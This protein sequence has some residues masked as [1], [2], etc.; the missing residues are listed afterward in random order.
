[1]APQL[2][3]RK[4]KD[5]DRAQLP[6]GKLKDAEKL[7]LSSRKAKDGDGTQVS[8]R[9][10]PST[11]KGKHRISKKRTVSPPLPDVVEAP[12]AQESGVAPDISDAGAWEIE[13]S[14]R[15][16]DE[17]GGGKATEPEAQESAAMVLP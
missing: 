14:P 3:N 15:R 6:A 7:Q 17:E 5:S 11:P 2:S 4:G 1:M 13:P 16:A 12:A 8:S 10:A 9:K